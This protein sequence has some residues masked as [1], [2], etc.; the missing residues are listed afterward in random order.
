MCHPDIQIQ[1]AEYQG[2]LTDAN[3]GRIDK[4]RQSAFEDTPNFSCCPKKSFCMWD[5]CCLESPLN[6]T[7]LSRRTVR[8]LR[9]RVSHRELLPHSLL[10]CL[11]SAYY[12]IPPTAQP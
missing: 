2:I 3:A 11:C 1:P 7:P 4:R 9:H 8:G 12:R 5:R 10:I 6:A